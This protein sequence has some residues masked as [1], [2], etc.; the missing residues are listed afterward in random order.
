MTVR[1]RLLLSTALLL[2][3][4]V[5]AKPV[6]QVERGRLI[7]LGGGGFCRLFHV[8]DKFHAFVAE[9]GYVMR[10]FDE[11]FK[12]TGLERALIQ[13][14]GSDH[15][16][17]FDGECFYHFGGFWVDKFD[18]K[19]NL[20]ATTGEIGGENDHFVDQNIA[21]IHG[22]IYV[23]TEYR[24]NP[25][26]WKRRPRGAGMQ[27]IPPNTR[28]ARAAHIRVFDKDLSLLDG[29]YLMIG[30]GELRSDATQ[31]HP[32]GN[33]DKVR[34]APPEHGRESNLYARRPSSNSKYHSY[35]LNYDQSKLPHHEANIFDELRLVEIGRLID[36]AGD[37]AW[38]DNHSGRG[39]D[40]CRV[41]FVND[42]FYAFLTNHPPGPDNI[43]YVRGFDQNWQF[44]GFERR[45]TPPGE[46]DI[47]QDIAFDEEYVYEYA[48]QSRSGKI[49]KFDSNFNLVKQT[50]VFRAGGLI[51]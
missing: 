33:L 9:R 11:D 23:G 20:I 4:S 14:R 24:E 15:D 19:G 41:L 51:S 21:V 42:T 10:V 47:D 26:L 48:V 32:F 39:G 17:A 13:R 27:N 1:G 49:R 16:M 34:R 40:F 31:E 44:T 38:R 29:Q 22:R 18:L 37:E 6:L 28:V 43:Y 8:D 5:N 35:M 46:S 2:T 12:P 25:A 7:R 30:T 36:V 3:L 50:T 45:L